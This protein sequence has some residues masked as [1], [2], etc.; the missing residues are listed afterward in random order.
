MSNFHG[1]IPTIPF[2]ERKI[3]MIF[4]MHP[5]LHPSFWASERFK[6]KLF[7]RNGWRL[8]RGCDAL[9][10]RRRGG[11]AAGRRVR[12]GGRT[13]AAGWMGSEKSPVASLGDESWVALPSGY[14]NIA[15]EN[16][17]L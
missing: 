5:F 4:S 11:A 7:R 14:V 16:D 15:I 13:A 12:V 17:H 6:P 8:P 9:A 10:A 1:S 3:Y 2:F